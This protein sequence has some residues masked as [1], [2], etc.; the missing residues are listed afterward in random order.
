MTATPSLQLTST[1]YATTWSMEHLIL[2]ECSSI[3]RELA[4]LLRR[5]RNRH[6]DNMTLHGKLQLTDTTKTTFGRLVASG[7]LRRSGEGYILTPEGE[8]RLEYLHWTQVIEPHLRM[9]RRVY[10]QDVADQVRK[11]YR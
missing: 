8:A 4:E 1:S 7:H 9:V 10:G 5:A 3:P 11:A 6:T 2:H